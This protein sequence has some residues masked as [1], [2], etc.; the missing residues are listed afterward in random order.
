MLVIDDSG[1]PVPPTI[2]Q[3][4]DRDIRELYRRDK[5][6]NKE[7]YIKECIVIYYLGDPKSPPHQAGLSYNESFKQAIEQADLPKDYIPDTLVRRLIERY[8]NENIGE[9]GRTVENALKALHNANLLISAINELATEKLTT[10]L[11][12]EDIA[13]ITTLVSSINAQTKELPTLFKK[14]QEAKENLMYEQETEISRGG[15]AVTSS[16][17]AESYK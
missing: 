1:Q 11:T 6:E 5:S 9:A 15:D 13:M 12:A 8:Y 17:D 2:R 16:M 14:L 10:K 7:M 3:L 4:V